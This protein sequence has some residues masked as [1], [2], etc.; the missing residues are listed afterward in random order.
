M[1]QVNLP[2]PGAKY[3]I[4]T[5]FWHAGNGEKANFRT[6]VSVSYDQRFFKVEFSCED[7]FYTSENHFKQHNEPLFNQEVFEVFIGV[8]EAD[9]THYLEVEI[10]PNNALW[11]GRI[12]NPQLGEGPQ[13]IVEQFRPEAVGIKYAAQSSGNSWTGYLHI[14][15]TLIGVD[16]RGNYRLN[17]Y[18]IRSRVSHGGADW[19]CGPETCDF[20]CWNSTLSGSEPAFHRPKRFGHLKVG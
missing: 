5:P 8:G 19:Q 20:V 6:Q 4:I 3:S 11:I 16:D 2:F 1:T 17:L 18:R 9:C 14:P 12:F 15:W 13:H 7:N 10:N